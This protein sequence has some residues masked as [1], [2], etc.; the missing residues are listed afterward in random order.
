[1]WGWDRRE[2]EGNRRPA[3]LEA[4]HAEDAISIVRELS[5]VG[6]EG[7]AV[8][9]QAFWWLCWSPFVAVVGGAVTCPCKLVCFQNI[10][11]ITLKQCRPWLTNIMFVI[12]SRNVDIFA[13]GA[14]GKLAPNSIPL[15]HLKR[16]LE[17]CAC[18]R[19]VLH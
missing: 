9:Q 2:R 18:T 12:W 8:C 19:A 16:I 6:V 10:I 4:L 14:S 13:L 11:L 3:C 17:E 7:A 5:W 1:M 15:Q